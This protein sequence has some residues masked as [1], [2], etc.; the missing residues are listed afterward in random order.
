MQP[1]PLR[2]LAI[3]KA[4]KDFTSDRNFAD[5]DQFRKDQR[6]QLQEVISNIHDMIEILHFRDLDTNSILIWRT[7]VENLYDAWHE[8]LEP[9]QV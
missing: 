6:L 2:K 4:K 1:Y 8:Y 9:A 5:S 3:Y 7:R